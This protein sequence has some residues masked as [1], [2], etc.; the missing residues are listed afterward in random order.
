[1]WNCTDLWVPIRLKRIM[2]ARIGV[3]QVMIGL[4]SSASGMSSARMRGRLG[5]T[6]VKI[7]SQLVKR[8]GQD[9]Y[10]AGLVGGQLSEGL[11]ACGEC[12]DF[13][14]TV[15]QRLNPR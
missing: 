7:F 8:H 6:L 5:P 3:A 4:E 15:P 1:M 12:L 9:A 2:V 13:R 11:A 14:K 10:T